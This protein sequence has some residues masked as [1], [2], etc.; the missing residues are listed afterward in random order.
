[1]QAKYVYKTFFYNTAHKKYLTHQIDIV[2]K[3][4]DFFLCVKKAQQRVQGL[5]QDNRGESLNNPTW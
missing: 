4:R 3:P 2:L 5:V 1:M